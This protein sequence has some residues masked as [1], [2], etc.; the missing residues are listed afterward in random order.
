MNIREA[1]ALQAK[2]CAELGSP[3]MAQLLSVIGERMQPGSVVADRILNWK[4]DVSP[5]GQS[6]PLRLAGA[7]HAL[8]LSGDAIKAL[9]PPNQIDSDTLWRA[10]NHAFERESDRILAFLKSPP[11][12]NEVRRAAAIVPGLHAVAAR[13]R[14]P[15]ILVEIGCSGGLN[16]RADQFLVRARSAELGP[17]SSPAHITP[18]WSGAMPTVGTPEV[19]DRIGVDINP[20]IPT[21]PSDAER[22]LAYLWPDQPD[23]MARTRAAITLA[24][25]YPA[26]I[27]TA[28]ASEWLE[29]GL[30]DLN[31]EAVVFLF[32]TIAWQYLPED[33]RRIGEGHLARAGA[34]RRANAPLV[35]FAMEADGGTGAGLTLTVWPSGKTISLGRA[36]FHGRWIEWFPSD[37]SEI[38]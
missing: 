19:I 4:G 35:R 38:D 1:F 32:H 2:A 27:V 21:V 9:Y 12:T 3:F 15:I 25:D 6:V 18:D 8:V 33:R 13:F 17:Q 36:D 31:P 14:R 29:K 34:A 23:R 16:L 37:L 26:R 11:Q 10:V 5:F 20:L 7:L 30:D 28:D 22:L 24:N